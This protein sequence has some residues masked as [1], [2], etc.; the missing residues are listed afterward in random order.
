MTTNVLLTCAGRRNYLVEYFRDAVRGTG[1]VLAAD[2]DP[3]APAMQEADTA[4]VVPPVGRPDY[5]DHLLA[6]CAEHRVRL[7]VS[8]NDLEL[9]ILARRRDEFLAIGTIPVVSTPAVIDT[10]T[11]K[12]ATHRFLTGL[13]L[14]APR[15]YLSL[16]DARAAL[17]EGELTF[18]VVV[19]PRWGTASIGIE[20]PRDLEELELAFRLTEIRIRRTIIAGM[21]DA[22]PGRSVLVQE[23]LS[24]Q[25]HGLDVVNDLAGRHVT[26]FAK[27]KLSMR[28]GETDRAMTVDDDQ[29]RKLG[30]VLGRQLGHVGNLDCDVFVGDG[31]PYVLELNPRFGGGYPFSQVAGA[32]LPAALVSW[33]E[34]RVPETAWLTVRPDVVAA[35]CDRLVGVGTD[36]RG[37]TPP[38]RE[39]GR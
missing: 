14:P 19:K 16:A 12:W 15:T 34:G 21:S 20:Y 30:E 27:R 13:G 2:T 23:H 28:A 11:D 8:L 29:L 18:P 22:D 17:A 32:D 37:G 25:E 9:P 33:A 36:R 4:L 1:R 3:D 35:K 6:L 5:V 38:F 24:G 31:Q 10:C 7:V 26:T 39:I